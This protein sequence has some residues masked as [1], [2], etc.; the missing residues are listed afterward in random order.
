M[1][2]N[3][4]MQQLDAELCARCKGRGWCNRPCIVF[5]RIKKLLPKTKL[6]FSGSSPPEIFVGREGYPNVNTG[7]LSPQY[8]GDTESMSMPEIWHS[9]NFCIDNILNKRSQLIYSRFKSQITDARKSSKF[10]DAMKEI[11][12]ADKSVSTEVFLQ[13]PARA[14]ISFDQSMP[15]IGNPAPLKKISIQEN[16]HVD[17]KV[18]YITSDTDNKAANSIKSLYKATEISN[19]IKILSAG[20]LGLKNKRK[21]VPTR[22][23]VTAT[24]DTISK[25]LL[26]KIRYYP[27]I[28]EIMLFNAEYV[29]NHYEFLLLPDKFS[30]EVIEAKMPG[31][32]WNPFSPSIVVMQDN[33]GF[34][35]RKHYASNVTGAYYSNRLA[36]CEYF[37]KIKKQA[38]CLVMRECRPEYYA[39]LGT[40]ILRETSR[41][42][43]SKSPEKFNTIEEALSQSQKRMRL[44]VSIF[45]D[46]S[47]IIKNFGKQAR[48][49]RWF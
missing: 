17:R 4:K 48:L 43:L 29:G 23:A 27:E 9:K 47:W 8:Y 49:S 28:S 16:P 22:W 46:K 37:E 3:L 11:S 6:H 15:L 35:G 21:L 36:L 40:G 12:L 2:P 30:F 13:K 45:K 20:M 24:D 10:L 39:P 25:S 26:E 19:I 14:S 31:S 33:E 32:V 7:I 41:E 44:P 5:E 18:D 42:A 38:S 1:D 34:H